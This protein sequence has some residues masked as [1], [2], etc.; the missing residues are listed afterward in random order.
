MP[1]RE[2]VSFV[3]GTAKLAGHLF[4]PGAA[5]PV[6]AT[7]AQGVLLAGTWTSVKEQMADRYAEELARRGYAALAFDF[8]GYG[9]SEGA[10]RDYESPELKVRDLHAAADF[11]TGHPAVGDGQLG[12]LGVCAG[13]MYASALA[14]EDARVG[15]LAL[16]APWLHDRRICE[17]NYGGTEGIAAKKAAAA[18][19]RRRYE[20]SGEVAYVPVVS[21][22]D[23]DAAMPF[24]IDFYLNPERGG[25]PQWPNRY[26]VMAWSEWL[27]FDAV[28][29]AAKVT[30]PALLVHSEDAAIPDGARRF[31]DGLMGERTFLWTDGV[32]FDFYDQ[33]PQVGLAA[34]AVAEHFA[35]TL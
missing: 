24:D 22:S 17:E 13:S 32:Q 19:A 8:T 34:D 27:D 14:A 3:S 10:P 23:P 5:S 7:P 4:L 20:A 30:T 12:A 28:A 21:G 16:V 15:S 11:L 31:Y 29:L 33:A 18:A 25:I 9:E 26:A 6:E 2:H 35:R 1:L